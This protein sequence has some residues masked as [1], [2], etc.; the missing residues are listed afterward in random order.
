MPP[1]GL[2]ALPN[3]RLALARPLK[4]F[5]RGFAPHPS[6]D[7]APDR[8]ASEAHQL[9]LWSHATPRPQRLQSPLLS[10]LLHAWGWLRMPCT[11]AR[12][13][14]ERP[15]GV[16]VAARPRIPPLRCVRK[17]PAVGDEMS[18]ADKTR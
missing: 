8:Q 3:D 9:Q 11:P 13:E 7:R 18:R 6:R 10:L 14:T 1:Y 4:R 17:N 2:R 16:Y 5:P 12:P 15:V